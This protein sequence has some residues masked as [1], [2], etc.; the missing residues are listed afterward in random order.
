MFSFES[1]LCLFNS[2]Y[3]SFGHADHEFMFVLASNY[4]DRKYSAFLGVGRY[5]TAEGAIS[6]HRL[7]LLLVILNFIKNIFFGFDKISI[8]PQCNQISTTKFYTR[9]EKKCEWQIN[10]VGT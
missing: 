5:F 4:W 10:S 3:E 1:L 6:I 7:S 8:I 2:K 9:V